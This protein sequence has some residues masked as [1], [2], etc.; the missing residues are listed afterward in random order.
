MKSPDA[1]T[2]A[3]LREFNPR[4]LD[5][6]GALH[7]QCRHLYTGIYGKRGVPVRH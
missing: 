1:P 6:E 4:Y 3:V 7:G 2:Q 5:A